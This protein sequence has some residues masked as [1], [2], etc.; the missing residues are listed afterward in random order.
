[1]KKFL[2]R[3]ADKIIGVLSG[4]DRVIFRGHLRRLCYPEG[5]D[6]F[7]AYRKVLRQDFETFAK[8]TT[9]Q[10]K[11]ASLKAAKD[12]GRPVIYLDSPS[13]SKEDVVKD[14]LEKSP[15]DRG[16]VCVIK[17]VEPCMTWDVHRSR[18]RKRIEFKFVRGQCEHLYHYSKDAD[19]GLMH[20]RLQTWLPYMIQVHVNGREWLAN[21]MRQ[22]GIRFTKADNCFPWIEDVPRAQ[23]LFNTLQ[24]FHWK[25]FLDGLALDVNPACPQIL[26]GFKVP[27]FWTLHQSEWATDVMF[28]DPE[29]LA[30]LY[31]ALVRYSMSDLHC[32]DIFRFLG[33]KLHGNFEGEALTKLRRRLEGIC[34]KF[35]IDSNWLKMYDK[36]ASILRLEPTINN[37]K[38]FL[39]MR[40]A[41]GGGIESRERRPL[42]RGI[43]DIR[44][45]TNIC[46]AINKRA[47]DHLSVV[48]EPTPV[49]NLVETV[50]KPTELAGRRVRALQPWS[51][52]DVDLLAAVAHGDFL[53]Q[54]FR[55]RDLVPLLYPNPSN[56]QTEN[57]KRSARISRL[58]RLLRAHGLIEKVEGTHRY[59]VTYHGRAVIAA[60]LGTREMPLSAVRQVA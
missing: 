25:T 13:I 6:G 21:K 29:S 5:L 18:E 26:A 23:K 4:F 1:M 31:S 7:L 8:Q 51:Q 33:K 56:D 11:E 30:S 44:L 10:L 14:I 45:R 47:L 27:Y 34:V 24:G 53:I 52:P 59:L 36:F 19:F 46:Q 49:R 41:E 17:C 48:A 3:F 42:R 32:D 28:R 12:A 2:S 43:S 60:V 35:M 50:T 22:E 16:L 20:V 54:G 15:V 57:R 39:V 37:P 38:F 40:R 9:T 55:N 58:L